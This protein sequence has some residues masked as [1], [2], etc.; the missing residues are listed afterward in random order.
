MGSALLTLDERIARAGIGIWPTYREQQKWLESRKEVPDERAGPAV[1]THQA[2]LDRFYR[3][4]HQGLSGILARCKA[5]R[6]SLFT[7]RRSVDEL[8]LWSIEAI[9]TETTLTRECSLF[10]IDRLLRALRTVVEVLAAD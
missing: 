7:V 8:T 9:S 10:L 5:S 2:D 6:G 3:N 1:T 4:V